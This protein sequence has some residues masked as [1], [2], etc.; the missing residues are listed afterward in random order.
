[1]EK[2]SEK[3]LWVKQS[4]PCTILQ[5]SKLYFEKRAGKLYLSLSFNFARTLVLKVLRMEEI[6]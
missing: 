2:L 5:I 6:G 1:M 4:F 3:I